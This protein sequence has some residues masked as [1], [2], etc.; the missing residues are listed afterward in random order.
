M[1]GDSASEVLHF[2]VTVKTYPTP[3]VKHDETV[4]T[5][6]VTEDGRWAR[7]YP[8]A[9]RYL[10][11]RQQYKLYDWVEVPARKRPPEKDRRKESYEPVGQ[12]RVLGHVGT[13]RNWEERR[14]LVVPYAAASIEAILDGYER[15]GTSLGIIKPREVQEVVIE[16]ELGGW[17]PT[18]RRLFAQLQLF[19]PQRKPLEKP[20][21]RI[22][23][24]F[25]CDDD[26]C[27]GHCLQIADWGL[28]V[29]YLRTKEEEGEQAALQKTT[30]KCWDLVGEDR[31]AY[32][33]VG[34]RYP[35]RSFMVLGMFSPKKERPG[36]RPS[37]L[38]G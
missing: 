37:T 29:L 30:A 31:D 9:F 28:W 36:A 18:H 38:F 13:E 12:V 17:S 23:F 25:R 4:C 26:R 7:L 2:L 5:G 27:R 8:V 35:Y 11:R 24:R 1:R 33:Y 16:E 10:P 6:G 3:S 32:L 21:H 15:E 19:G 22:S 14:R 34:T 20:G